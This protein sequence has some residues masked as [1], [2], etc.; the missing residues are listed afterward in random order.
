V[1]LSVGSGL[2]IVG[3]PVAVAKGTLSV[4]Q[5]VKVSWTVKAGSTGGEYC[6][7]ADAVGIVSGSLGPWHDYPTYDYEDFIGGSA[8]ASASVGS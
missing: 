4:G 1:T 8:S 6:L 7:T 3:D 5:Q 2:S